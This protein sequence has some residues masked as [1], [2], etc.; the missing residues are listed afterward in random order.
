MARLTVRRRTRTTEMFVKLARTGSVVQ[1]YA[2]EPGSK[3]Q[4]L[5]EKGGF[6]AN[7]GDKIRVNGAL[8]TQTTVL[9][10]GDIVTVAG[11]VEGGK[12]K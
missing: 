1:E 5:L 2:L 4:D 11:R 6:S 9:K 7:K 3:V 10:N 8:A 12:T